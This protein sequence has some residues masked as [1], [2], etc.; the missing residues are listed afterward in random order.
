MPGLVALQNLGPGGFSVATYVGGSVWD[1]VAETG[2]G[3]Q[4]ALCGSAGTDRNIY[5]ACLGLETDSLGNAVVHVNVF[6]F[7]KS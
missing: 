4:P 7:A 5:V 3:A 2:V 1:T 6:A